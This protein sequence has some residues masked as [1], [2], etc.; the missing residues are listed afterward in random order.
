MGLPERNHFYLQEVVDKLEITELDLQYYVSHGYL[1]ACVY[2]TGK[3][4]GGKRAPLFYVDGIPFE[5][6]G[7]FH[8][9][10]SSCREIF[11]IGFIYEK[12]FHYHESRSARISVPDD[13]PGIMLQKNM[14][15]IT[16]W[17]LESFITRHELNGEEKKASNQSGRPSVMP[18]ILVEYER[19]VKN[20][21]AYKH[22]AREALALRDWARLNIKDKPLPSVNTIRGWLSEPKDKP[23]DAA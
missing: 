7:C 5:A 2:I 3:E 6:E 14:L 23:A 4:V 20:K 9:D 16:K 17:D 10:P 11:S 8:I 15:V 18:E 12:N 22:K 21:E 1:K 19:R 13:Q